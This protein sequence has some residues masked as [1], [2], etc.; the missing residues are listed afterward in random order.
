MSLGAPAA[1]AF[2]S[3]WTPGPGNAMLAASG[4]TFGFGR[5]L[6]HALGVPLGFPLMIFL[7]A[8]GLGEAFR[9]SA[10][11]RETLHRAGAALLAWIA[12]RIDPGG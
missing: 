6:P 9:E 5:T 4:A 8:L 10:A 11:L 12:W 2:A 3:V 7:V 1:L